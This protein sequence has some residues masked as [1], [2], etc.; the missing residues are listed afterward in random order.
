M[1]RQAEA[2]G[3]RAYL[4][5]ESAL[6]DTRIVRP[7]ELGGFSLDAQWNDDFHHSL[8]TALTD[9]RSGYYRDFGGLEDLAAAWREGYVYSGQYSKF[10]QRAHGNSSRSIPARQLVVFAQNHDQ[11]GNRMVGDRLQAMI[12][13]E[14]QKLAAALVLLSP[15]IPLIFMGEEYGETAPFLYFVSHTDPD[16]VE[17]VRKGRAREFQAF[18]WQE[19]PP[20][21]QDEQTFLRSKL[22]MDLRTDGHHQ[23][24]YEFYR[25]LLGMRVNIPALANL[26]KKEMTVTCDRQ[27]NLLTARRRFG[28]DEACLIFNFNDGPKTITVALPEGRWTRRI[29]SGDCR[30]GGPGS[31]VPET[32]QANGPAVPAPLDAAAWSVVVFLQ[33]GASAA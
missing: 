6:N 2:S 23:T 22:N 3:R 19:K 33:N 29:D 16:L 26:S 27:Q 17:A 24:L 32:L 28:T 7:R 12:S 10:L 25:E 5:A 13:F 15:F 31:G 18:D 9:E 30:W 20:D 11:V 1:H 4:I 8:H 21:P 14:K